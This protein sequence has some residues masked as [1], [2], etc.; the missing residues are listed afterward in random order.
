MSNEPNDDNKPNQTTQPTQPNK[1]K[2]R[3][4]MPPRREI[5]S[6]ATLVPTLESLMSDALFIIGSELSRY[7]Q[8]ASRGVTLDLKEARA[9]QSY[10]ES[11]VKL[12]KEDRERARSEDLTN[13]SDE[14]L[15]E[16]AKEVLKIDHNKDTE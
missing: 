12:S 3:I 8:K 13:L 6:E 10:M 14:E 9:V 5:K 11:L 15:K 16:L 1:P 4:V 7:R 2:K